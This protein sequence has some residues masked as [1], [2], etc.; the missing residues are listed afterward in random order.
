MSSFDPAPTSRP[1][2]V[3]MAFREALAF[4]ADPGVPPANEDLAQANE[5]STPPETAAPAAPASSPVEV[6]RLLALLD[7]A[8]VALDE[9][10]NDSL[11]AQREGMVALALAIA[12]RVVSQE[13]AEDGS[14]RQRAVERWLEE[15]V[16]E[17]GTLRE[18][19]RIALSPDDL[20]A[21]RQASSLQGDITWCA[22]PAVASGQAR[23]ES[24]ATN[25]ALSVKNAMAAIEKRMSAVVADEEGAP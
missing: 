13:L 12:E 7:S 15:A 9:T 23:V 17:L 20:D 1:K 16:A 24:G 10:L 19:L 25:M 8:A 21:L 5:L 3:A 6:E 18:P 14:L 11:D 4:E 22:D 2:F